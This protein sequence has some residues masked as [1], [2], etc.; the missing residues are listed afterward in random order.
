MSR[1]SLFS[2]KTNPVTVRHMYGM[3][4]EV[5]P[6]EPMKE[7]FPILQARRDKNLTEEII[8]GMRRMGPPQGHF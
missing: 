5:R 6:R 3:R 1:S 7:A 2:K 8:I 4:R